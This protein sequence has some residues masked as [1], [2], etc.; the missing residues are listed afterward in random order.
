[1]SLLA[2]IIV[3]LALLWLTALTLIFLRQTLVIVPR[4]KKQ[5]IELNGRRAAIVKEALA[6]GAAITLPQTDSAPIYPFGGWLTLA[7]NGTVTISGQCFQLQE[8]FEV[9]VTD[10]NN[11]PRVRAVSKGTGEILIG[12]HGQFFA[13]RFAANRWD[14]RAVPNIH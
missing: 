7:S 2:A 14:V 1:M 5:L 3:L 9:T 11:I 13:A 4:V 12:S 6:I 8:V 10:E